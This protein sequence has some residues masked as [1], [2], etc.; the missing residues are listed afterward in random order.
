MKVLT[1]EHIK[2]HGNKTTPV[3]SKKATTA[4]STE[5]GFRQCTFCGKSG[6]TVERFWT[7]QKK[8]IVELDAAVMPLDAEEIKFS[9]EAIMVATAVYTIE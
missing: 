5:H 3:K 1:N 6:H 4:F 8:R 2:R 7:R 9:V